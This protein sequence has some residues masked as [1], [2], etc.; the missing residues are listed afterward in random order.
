[1]TPL[2]WI[3][4]GILLILSELLA[5]SI[6]AVFIGLGAVLTGI[7]LHLGWIDSLSVQLLVFSALSLLTLLLARRKLKAMFVG[8]VRHPNRHSNDFQQ[9]IGQ[10]VIVVNDFTDGTGRVELNGVH[11]DAYSKDALKKGDVAWVTHNQGIE[12]YVSLQP[13]DPASRSTQ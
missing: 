5:T 7:L 11:W 4:I 8:N 6:M 3:A 12:L 13:T 2:I 1:M 10:R 9:D